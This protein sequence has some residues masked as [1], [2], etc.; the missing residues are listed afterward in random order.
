MI[1]WIGNLEVQQRTKDGM[2]NATA[3]LKQ[4]NDYVENGD[5]ELP[6]YCKKKELKDFFDNKNTEEF[7]DALVKEENLNRDNSPYL[8]S[9][10]KNGGTWM[11]PF[12]FAKFAMWLNPAI[13]VRVIRFV[14]DKM[15]E[16]RNEAG[17][18]YKELGAAVSKIVDKS[19]MPVA[20][21]N[22]SKGINYVVFGD[23][24]SLIRN[25]KGD[26][27]MQRELFAMERKV[28]DLINDG[29]IKSYDNA[30]NYLRMK[31]KEKYTPTLLQ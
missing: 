20:M 14:R 26:E 12:L 29:F 24:Y 22:I 13:E 17:D 19:F 30:M 18:A 11:H 25:D 1:R 5:S 8:A 23:H 7:I 21:S 3:L 9:R 31:W 2:F 4:W 15:I 6:S 10:G 28:A 16:Y 27:G